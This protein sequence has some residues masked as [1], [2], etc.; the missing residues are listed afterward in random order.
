MR[1]SAFNTSNPASFL[2]KMEYKEVQK[3]SAGDLIVYFAH[4]DGTKIHP[5]ENRP[6]HFARVIEVREKTM[7]IE[8]RFDSSNQIIHHKIDYIPPEL[9]TSYLIYSK[10]VSS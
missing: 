6:L 10:K 9:G 5:D 8:S 2:S 1:S 7:I 3:G 4:T